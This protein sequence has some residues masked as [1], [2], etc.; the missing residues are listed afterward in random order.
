[1]CPMYFSILTKKYGK[2]EIKIRH[3]WI[4]LASKKICRDSLRWKG[5]EEER[6]MRK[7]LFAL[8]CIQLLNYNIFF[9][10]SFLLPRYP[11]RICGILPHVNFQYSIA[12][13]HLFLSMPVENSFQMYTKKIILKTKIKTNWMETSKVELN[14]IRKLPWLIY[15]NIFLFYFS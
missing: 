12:P 6:K 14:E 5:I 13:F 4:E 7:I 8:W 2:M 1:M 11:L 3:L 10:T 15:L 9:E